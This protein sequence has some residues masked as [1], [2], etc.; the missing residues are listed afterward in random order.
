MKYAAEKAVIAIAAIMGFGIIGISLIS[1]YNDFVNGKDLPYLLIDFLFFSFG[2][3]LAG[4]SLRLYKRLVML[5][6]VT[7]SAFEDV[8]YARLRPVLEEIAYGTAEVNE[9]KTRIVN[10]EKKLEK[11]E[12]E[13]VR[14]V[15]ISVPSPE[16]IVLRKTAFYMRTVVVAMF[17]FGAYLFLLNYNLPYEPYLYTLLYILWWFFVTKE[18]NLFHRIEAWVVLGIPVLLVPAGTIILRATIGLVPLMGLI[19][20]TVVLY[21]YLYYLYAKTLSVEEVEKVSTNGYRRENFLYAKTK[22]TCRKLVEWFR[23]L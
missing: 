12:E 14:P 19:F 11:M 3:V 22:E 5:S 7:E 21:A 17:F 9:V 23:G 1:M 15:E 18:F 4:G 13:L 16:S 6:V 8:I 20:L 10:L 2:T